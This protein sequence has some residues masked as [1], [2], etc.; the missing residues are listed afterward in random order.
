MTADQTGIGIIG[1]GMP[2]MLHLEAF[3]REVHDAFGEFPYLVGSAARGKEWRDVDVRLM[4]PDDEFE[5]L[6]P[7]HRKPDRQDGKWGL[8]CAALSELARMRTGLPVD[9]QIQKTSWANER[10]SGVRHALGIHDC[11]GQ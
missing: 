11:N 3:G 10:Y 2:A 4:L 9:F 1:V 8:I 5:S 6:F 7:L